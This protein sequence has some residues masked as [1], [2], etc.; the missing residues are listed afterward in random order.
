MTTKTFKL[1]AITNVGTFNWVFI[2]TQKPN[3]D[4]PTKDPKYSITF[5]FDKKDPET[6]KKLDQY[7]ECI[8]DALEKFFGSKKPAKFRSPIKDGDLETDSEN[9]PRYPGQWYFEAKSTQKPGLVDGDRNEILSTGAVWSG[10][11]GKLSIGFG[12][13][14]VSSTKGV[15]IYMNNVQ[16]I[17]NSAPKQGGRKNAADDFNE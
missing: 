9:N 4:D 12:A 13:Y 6:T 10:C 17:D 7:N 2:D 15:T 16:L 1:N 11:K 14:D 5:A 8:S 3:K